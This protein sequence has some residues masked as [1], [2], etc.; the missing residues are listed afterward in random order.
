M[1]V[2]FLVTINLDDLS[3][4]PGVAAEIQDDIENS[5]FEVLSVAPWARPALTQQGIMPPS[6]TVPITTQQP[7]QNIT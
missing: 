7:N 5:G 1:N 4:L 2:T 6:P 3:D